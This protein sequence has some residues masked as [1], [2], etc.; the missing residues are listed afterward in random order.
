MLKNTFTIG[1]TK[2]LTI[3]VLIEILPDCSHWNLLLRVR[4][5]LKLGFRRLGGVNSSAKLEARFEFPVVTGEVK[6]KKKFTFV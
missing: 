4:S 2:L 6:G 5:S 3:L 1:F